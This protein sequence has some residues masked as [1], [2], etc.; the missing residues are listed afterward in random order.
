[1]SSLDS[2]DSTKKMDI[3]SITR[4]ADVAKIGTIISALPIPAY[5][6]DNEHKVVEWS[7]GLEPLLGLSK[8]EML[9]HDGLFAR[10]EEGNLIKAISNHI[11]E[12]P[13]NADEVEHIERATSQ[14]TEAPVYESPTWLLNDAGEERFIRFTAVPLY[15][16]G[17][18]KGVFQL[19]Q[20]ETQRKRKQEATEELIE[21][22]IDTLQQV[23]KG[24]FGATATFE[25]TEYIE[26]DLLEVLEQVN[27]MTDNLRTVVQAI[28]QQTEIVNE[29]ISQTTQLADEVAQMTQRQSN[30]LR[31]SVDELQE[32]SARMEQVAAVSNEVSQ[33]AENAGQSVKRGRE[34]G[35]KAKDST[36]QLAET[37]EKLGDTMADL[38]KD[39]DKI[40]EV[41]ELIRNISEEIDI[42]ALN[43][44]I[45]ASRVGED[46]NGFAVVAD[47]VKELA[48]KTGEHA[49]KVSK[50]IETIQ[51]QTSQT[52]TIID[53]TEDQI[54]RG[55]EE[56]D[57]TLTELNK[58]ENQVEDVNNSI[59]EVAKANDGQADTVEELTA[60]LEEEKSR[61]ENI[62]S[63]M[64]NIC[65]QADTQQNAVETLAEE[66]RKLN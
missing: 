18:F 23:S 9:G 17:K 53:E 32:F 10:D 43:A 39:M 63:S 66:V 58:I 44:N 7:N 46:G 3:G 25:Q 27:N 42:L 29:G 28:E 49:D 50:Q 4:G 47:E 51:S 2:D 48:N 20:D 14:Y 37:G 15:E 26:T 45:E 41:V 57:K 13:K 64:D 40:E 54:S 21:E 11:V 35:D 62:R 30:S 38:E 33:A 8:N 5:I 6:L 36:K 31:G 19:C 60:T 52:V 12:D 65:N 61:S 55:V 1:M 24:N 34:A 56:V 59:D 16:D 22:I